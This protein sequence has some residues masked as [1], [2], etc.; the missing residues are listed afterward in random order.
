[1]LEWDPM[2]SAPESLWQDRAFVLFWTARVISISGSTITAVVLPILVFQLTGSA[3]QT[4]LLAT[5]EVLPYFAFGL[6]AGA[7]ADR[8]DRRRLMVGSNLIQSLLVASIPAA[9]AMG[10]LSLTQVYVVAVLVMAAFVWFDAANFGALPALIGRGRIVAANSAILAA[11]TLVGIVAPAIGGGL[12]AWLGPA[13][14]IVIDAATFLGSALL[15]ATIRR[16]FNQA[17]AAEPAAP[18]LRR[19]AADIGE[20]LAFLWHQRLVRTMTIVGFGNSFSAGAVVGLLVVYAVRGLG[21]AATD[22]RIGLLYT[23]TAAGGLAASLLLPMLARRFPVGRIT[24]AGLL[25]HLGALVALALATSLW[26]GVAL[27]GL[28]QLCNTLVI[29]NGIAL[30]QQVT[31]DHLQARVNTTARMVAWGGQPFGAAVGGAL[32]EA[33]DVRTALLLVGAGVAASVV[34]GWLSP[35]RDANPAQCTEPVVEAQ[36]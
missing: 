22:G 7:L 12:A 4:S 6:V 29:I 21:L 28:W 26:A 30:R 33:F 15:L 24:L 3:L 32:A 5:L 1:M 25:A 31:P 8:V 34:Y 18:I 14:V 10:A 35:L 23:A 17:R 16:P 20:G 13:N 36:P 27:V 19:I 9:A 2:I 11:T